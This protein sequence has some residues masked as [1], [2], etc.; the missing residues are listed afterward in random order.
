MDAATELGRNLVS[1]HQILCVV[2]TYT[3][4]LSSKVESWNN[5]DSL[6]GLVTPLILYGRVIF[7][8]SSKALPCSVFTEL[9][10][11]TFVS[12]C[13]STPDCVSPNVKILMQCG[14]YHLLSRL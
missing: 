13:L 1:K 2:I 10:F 3:L 9:K 6:G 11:C 4:V 12:W 14:L 7:P 5:N 8:R